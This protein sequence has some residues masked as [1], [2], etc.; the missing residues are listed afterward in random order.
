MIYRRLARRAVNYIFSNQ[1]KSFNCFS[2]NQS[3]ANL[4]FLSHLLIAAKVSN[5]ND[6]IFLKFFFRHVLLFQII[7]QISLFEFIKKLLLN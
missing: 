6:I 4:K 7:T 5:D 2:I 1:L 3:F